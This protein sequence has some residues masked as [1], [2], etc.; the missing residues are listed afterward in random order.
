MPGAPD[1]PRWVGYNNVGIVRGVGSAVTRFRVGERVFSL[2]HHQSAYVARDSEMI[3]PVRAGPTRA[4][5]GTIDIESSVANA[6]VDADRALIEAC[7]VAV[8][9]LWTEPQHG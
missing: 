4:V 5:R 7:A 1:Y 3:V 9:A 2:Q 6:F 8:A